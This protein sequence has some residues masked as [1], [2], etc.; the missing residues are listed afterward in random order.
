MQFFNNIVTHQRKKTHT[1][2]VD[3]N[4][5]IKRLSIVDESILFGIILIL[6][7][8]NVFFFLQIY[9]PYYNDVY[10]ILEKDIYKILNAVE[11]SCSKNVQFYFCRND[12]VKQ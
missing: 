9:K 10:K 5:V 1:I 7:S 4:V 3:V 6:N 11:K 8:S 12:D 2:I